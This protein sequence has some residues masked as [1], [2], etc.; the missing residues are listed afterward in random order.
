[1]KPI[2]NVKLRRELNNNCP[3]LSQVLGR[4]YNCGNPSSFVPEYYNNNP[5]DEPCTK[6][7]WDTCPFNRRIG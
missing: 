6:K 2:S 5:G 7:D 1:M 4:V 3:H